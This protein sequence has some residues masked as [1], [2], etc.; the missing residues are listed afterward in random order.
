[1]SHFNFTLLRKDQTWEKKAPVYGGIVF[2]KWGH[3]GMIA[4]RSDDYIHC[5]GG[6]QGPSEINVILVLMSNIDAIMLPHGYT[7]RYYVLLGKLFEN[8]LYW[9]L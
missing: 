1:M 8:L 2:F 3:V 7:A 9:A 4:G 6:N 5:L